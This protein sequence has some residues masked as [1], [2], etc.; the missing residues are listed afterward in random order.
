LASSARISRSRGVCADGG[1]TFTMAPIFTK[2]VATLSARHDEQQTRFLRSN[3]SSDSNVPTLISAILPR[4]IE[5]SEVR[6]LWL[7][8][9]R[10]RMASS[11]SVNGLRMK[12]LTPSR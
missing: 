4:R 9:R 5:C 12:S 11:S 10:K 3:S 6:F 8:T 1:S 2:T 7:P